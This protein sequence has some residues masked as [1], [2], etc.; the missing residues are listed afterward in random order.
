MIACESQ[1]KKTYIISALVFSIT[2]G[3]LRRY[4]PG[5][6]SIIIAWLIAMFMVFILYRQGIKRTIYVCIISTVIILLVQFL[7]VIIFKFGGKELGFT[8]LNGLIAQS[9]G[10]VLVILVVIYIPIDF[11]FK[12]VVSNK[13]IEYLMLNIFVILFAII[14]GKVLAVYNY[15][16][17]NA[18]VIFSS[19]FCS[20]SIALTSLFI[21]LA[22]SL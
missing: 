22:D 18:F 9:V 1:N 19:F 6:Y 11:I 12:Y 17:L 13:T 14:Y 16:V 21:A 20:F 2:E 3:L 8:F 7:V 15:F 10:L 4:L 5:N